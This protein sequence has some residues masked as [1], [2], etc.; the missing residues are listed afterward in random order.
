MNNPGQDLLKRLLAGDRVAVAKGISTFP[1]SG[2]RDV[3]AFS[4]KSGA[5]NGTM[6][7]MSSRK[8]WDLIVALVAHARRTRIPRSHRERP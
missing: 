3:G 7:F 2:I 8:D 1:P 4:Q 6:G 5:V